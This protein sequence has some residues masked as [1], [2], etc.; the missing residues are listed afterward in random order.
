MSPGAAS[1]VGV[2]A[3]GDGVAGLERVVVGVGDA[4]GRNDGV[5]VGI[6]CGVGDAV[7]HGAG[8]GVGVGCG[9]GVGVN[10]LGTKLS[11]EAELASASVQAS[12]RTRCQRQE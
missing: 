10:A 3:V 5:A 4:V 12:G 6:G 11:L 1:T 2:V 9:A 7:D 8:V